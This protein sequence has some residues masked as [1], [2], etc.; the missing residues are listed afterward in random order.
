MRAAVSTT[1]QIG[2]DEVDVFA[3]GDVVYV[4]ADDGDGW[5]IDSLEVTNAS[6]DDVTEK[7]PK[8]ALDR[9]EEL[10]L[11]RATEKAEDDR[12]DAADAANDYARELRLERNR[13]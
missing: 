11:E 7:L 4:D 2:E 12:M 6:G 9:I 10:L 13:E 8:K 5:A 3:N 1:V